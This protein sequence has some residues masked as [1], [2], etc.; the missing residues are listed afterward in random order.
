MR[1]SVIIADD[2]P[3]TVK[4]MESVLGEASAL[5]IVGTATNGIEAI[6]LVKRLKPDCAVLDLSMPGANGLEVF[7]EAKRWSPDTCF[8]IVTGIS[9][10]SLFKQLYDSGIDGLFVKNS[11]PD[12]IRDGIVR[13]AHGER[14]ISDEA[15]DAIKSVQETDE[16][17]KRELEVLQALSLGKSNKEIAD[18]FG[19]SPKTIDTHR[20]NLLRKMNV[21]NTASLL[22]KAMKNGLLHI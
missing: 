18:K 13:V 1:K 3:F 12:I 9:A 6:A 19:I 20:T 14:T 21:N 15:L 4:G 2:H 11:P 7:I 17:S 22:V 8:A 16:L 5:H 10:A